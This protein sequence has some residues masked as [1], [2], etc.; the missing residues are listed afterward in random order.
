MISIPQR[1]AGVPGRAYA[2][3]D[4]SATFQTAANVPHAAMTNTNVEYDVVVIGAGVSGLNAAAK[5]RNLYNLRV[6]ECVC[7]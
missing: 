7:I 3:H 1:H 6:G 5:L 2:D 4:V